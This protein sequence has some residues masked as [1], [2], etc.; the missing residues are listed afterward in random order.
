MKIFLKT[1]IS[2]TVIFL[3]R[4]NTTEAQEKRG[5]MGLGISAGAMNYSGELDDNFT[6]VFTKPGFGA[7]AIF[8][9][10]SRLHFRL[11]ALHG[12]IT[13]SDAQ[14]NF[15]DNASRNLRFY[16]DIDEA[17][18]H[19]LY[20]LQNRSRGFTKRNFA[21]P[22]VFAGLSY[23]HF[24]PKRK[25]NGVEY[26]LQ[27]VG[28]EGQYLPGNY[29]APYKLYQ[30]SIPF[31]FGFKIKLTKNIDIGAET[32]FRRTFTDYL[33]DVSSKYPDKNA[34]LAAE[35]PVALFLSDPS[36]NPVSGKASFSDRGN[37]GNVDWYVYTNFHIT[38]YFTTAL[39]KQYKLKDQYKPNSCKG[40]MKPKKS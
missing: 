21:T 27:S 8:L 38:Y 13:A 30:F 32:G 12:T 29:P 35:G 33:D 11:S 15:T 14:A 18:F 37:S 6:L 4:S 26:D 31:G 39:F 17:S 25:I 19:I 9:V 34:L 22:Y 24:A 2:L 3:L 7:H 40:L 5:L 23:Y 28:T 36:I 16:S 1:F 10:F 20:T